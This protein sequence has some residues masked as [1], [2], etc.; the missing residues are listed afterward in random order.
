VCR[1]QLTGGD[2]RRSGKMVFEI[3]RLVFKGATT[4]YR[5]YRGAH[6]G[7]FAPTE[8]DRILNAAQQHTRVQEVSQV[9]QQDYPQS[10]TGGDGEGF[11]DAI[12]GFFEDLYG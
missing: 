12:G 8:A 2:G 11:L 5:I 10:D 4:A 6:T 3:G 7:D 1:R 9:A